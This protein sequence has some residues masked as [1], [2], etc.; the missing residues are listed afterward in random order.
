ME[1]LIA[2]YHGNA[3]VLTLLASILPHYSSL[4]LEDFVHN[5]KYAQ[6]LTS[7]NANQLLEYIYRQQLSPVQR[8]L[9]IA[10]SVYRQSVPL[11][12]ARAIIGQ[13]TEIT[14]ATLNIMLILPGNSHGV[15]ANYICLWRQPGSTAGRDNF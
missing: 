8:T 13:D 14:E 11:E 4:T 6:V 10:F 12:A 7:H 3:L 9:L 15:A 2:P 1:R 5:P